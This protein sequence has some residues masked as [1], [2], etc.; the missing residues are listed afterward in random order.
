MGAS[1]RLLSRPRD[2][3]F[4]GSSSVI[5]LEA[6]GR[7]SEKLRCFCMFGSSYIPPT[8]SYNSGAGS[9][10]VFC[11]GTLVSTVS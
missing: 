3:P 1:S 2:I 10:D 4:R 9:V 5:G 7:I 6:F 8:L 11:A